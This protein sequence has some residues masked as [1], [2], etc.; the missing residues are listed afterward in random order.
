M[1][2]QANKY[3]PIMKARELPKS[4]LFIQITVFLVR[5]S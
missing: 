3:A 5:L 4:G 2:N 1:G